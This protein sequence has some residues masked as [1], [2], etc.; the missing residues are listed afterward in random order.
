M[1]R[2][3]GLMEKMCVLLV[4]DVCKQVRPPTGSGL[5]SKGS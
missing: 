1:E 4:L 3:Q 2:L 5:S